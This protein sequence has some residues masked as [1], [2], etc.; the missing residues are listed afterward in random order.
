MAQERQRYLSAGLDECLTK[1]IDWDQLFGAIER[2]TPGG[3][4]PMFRPLPPASPATEEQSLLN[5]AVIDSLKEMA[6]PEVLREWMQTGL[7][8]Y[9]RGFAAMNQAGD[10]AE[11]VALEAHKIKGSGNTLGLPRIGALGARIEAEA[12]RGVVP[13]T[14]L[15]ELQQAISATK[16]RLAALDLL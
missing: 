11:T 13:E 3:N 1:P 12:K 4:E 8:G 7:S 2:H 16:A 5:P 10:D 14:M 9:E 6:G 15:A